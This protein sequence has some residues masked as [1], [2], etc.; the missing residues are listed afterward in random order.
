MVRKWC[1]RLILVTLIYT[2][3]E[4]TS[5]DEIVNQTK[6]GPKIAIIGSGISGSASA[7]FLR[8]LIPN[9]SIEV[10]EKSNIVGGRLKSLYF[11]G[12]TVEAGGSV[13]HNSNRYMKEFV[14]VTGLAVSKNRTYAGRTMGLFDGEKMRFQTTGISFI[15]AVYMIWRYGFSLFRLNA[16]VKETLSKFMTVYNLQSAGHAYETPNSLLQAMG[17]LN[18]TQQSL[19]SFLRANGVS[20]RLIGELATGVGRVNYGQHAGALNAL[21]GTISLS[22]DSGSLWSIAGG[23]AQVCTSLL[24]ASNVQLRLGSAVRRIARV[25]GPGP[26][27]YTVDWVEGDVEGTADYAAVV[28]AAPAELAGVAVDP[29]PPAAAKPR[30]FWTTHATF[31]RGRLRR[32]AVGGAA[33]P[34][35]VLTTEAPGLAFSSVGELTPCPAAGGACVYKAPPRPAPPVLARSESIGSVWQHLKPLLSAGQGRQRHYSEPPPPP[36]H[37]RLCLS[38]T[39][40]PPPRAVAGYEGR[41]PFRA[42]TEC[43]GGGGAGQVF[44]RAAL[45]DADLDALF[46]ARGGEPPLRVPWQVAPRGAPRGRA[47]AGGGDV[48]DAGARL[49]GFSFGCVGHCRLSRRGRA[50]DA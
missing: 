35:V 40:L 11:N 19:A 7:Y 28:L 48:G 1:E 17:L 50:P 44:S 31:V 20:D 38:C 33:P 6:S 10:F 8:K 9:A 4:Q 5:A 21:A 49:R 32:S 25:P 2:L 45:S 30:R 42:P 41:G 46:D 24:D 36:P 29:P 47:A 27:K 23:N 26:A 39:F 22:A 43:W 3:A 37:T 34:G 16:V 12:V 18:L 14:T 13:I 15:D